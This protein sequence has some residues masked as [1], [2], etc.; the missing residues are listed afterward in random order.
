MQKLLVAQWGV[1]G[2]SKSA[3]EFSIANSILNVLTLAKS[4]EKGA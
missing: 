2:Q 4:C 3:L 1:A